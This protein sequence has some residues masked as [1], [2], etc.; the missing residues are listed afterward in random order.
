MLPLALAAER[1]FVG[2][3][4]SESDNGA[5]KSSTLGGGWG[6]SVPK[7]AWPGSGGDGDVLDYSSVGRARRPP[8]M[9]DVKALV[10]EAERVGRVIDILPGRAA[11]TQ[12]TFLAGST[13]TP[14]M[15]ERSMTSPSSTVP[16]PGTLWPPP[17]M[18]RSTPRS[19][20]SRRPNPCAG[21]RRGAC[22]RTRRCRWRGRRHSGDPRR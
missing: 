3:D 11:P 9:P 13:R 16:N 15:G 12:A 4:R 10:R 1:A 5:C 14:F 22:G 20:P 18:A 2:S 19:R 6:G 7:Q 17:R 8:G 21:R